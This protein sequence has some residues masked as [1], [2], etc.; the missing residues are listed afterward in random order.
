MPVGGREPEDVLV[1]PDGDLITGVEDGRI[2]RIDGTGARAHDEMLRLG[3]LT[4]RGIAVMDLAVARR[5]R[6]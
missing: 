4:E 6:E 5:D 3:S 2:L 1:L